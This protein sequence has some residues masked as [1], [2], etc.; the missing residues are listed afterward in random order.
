MLRSLKGIPV[1]IVVTGA[2]GKSSVTRLLHAGFTACG[3]VSYARVTGVIPREL[4]PAGERP[5]RRTSPAHIRE[6]LWW[7]T[8]VPP[9]TQALV[10]ENSAVHPDLQRFAPD[11]VSPVLMVWTTLRTDHGEVWGPTREGAA[12][13]LLRGIPRGVPVAGGGELNIP[14][15][16]ALFRANDNP[17]Y[18][19]S[20]G[21]LCPS[22]DA[23]N[24]SLARLVLE[25]CN[26]GIAPFSL[27][28]GRAVRAMSEL[29]PD[30]ADFRVLHSGT[31][32][33]AA[34]FS[35]NDTESTARLFAETGWAPKETTLLYHHR[36]DRHARLENFLPWIES[37]PWKKKLFTRTGRP[38]FFP[39]KTFSKKNIEWNDAIRDPSTFEAWWKGRGRVFA[40]GNVAGWP[41][42]FLYDRKKD[43]RYALHF[44][45]QEP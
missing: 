22:H 43:S 33:L 35:A 3:L 18:T 4:S 17:L 30:I 37:R 19:L 44:D 27:D 23:E 11:L 9:E 45:A 28:I 29:P 16:L 15:L 5:I 6:M 10:V 36:P 32:E 20:S 21:F 14:R 31:D 34:A 42:E 40:C 13:A 41:I 1:R 39:K 26:S 7:M 38:V 12:R 25:L 2:R 24:L 8:Q